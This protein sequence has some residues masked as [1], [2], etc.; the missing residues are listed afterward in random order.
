MDEV[1]DQR[2]LWRE[3]WASCAACHAHGDRLCPRG[4]TLAAAVL[5]S[6]APGEILISRAAGRI[7]FSLNPAG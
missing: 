5:S 3:H 2:T 1:A 7:A 6:M 4:A